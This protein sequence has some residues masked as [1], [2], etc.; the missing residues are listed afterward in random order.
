LRR[1]LIEGVVD[2]TSRAVIVTGDL[3]AEP[4]WCEALSR[5]PIV[6]KYVRWSGQARPT[7]DLEGK[8]KMKEVKVERDDTQWP[9]LDNIYIDTSA[10]LL[11]EELVDKVSSCLCDPRSSH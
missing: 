6:S 9:F 1:F 2:G 10:V 3:R 8:G 7:I 5:N 4:W 11:N